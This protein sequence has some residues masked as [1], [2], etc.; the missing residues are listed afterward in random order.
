MSSNSSASGASGSVKKFEHGDEENY[1]GGVT[2]VAKPGDTDVVPVLTATDVAT[3][4][5]VATA[6][7]TAP[8]PP[9]FGKENSTLSVHSMMRNK[10][11]DD[12]YDL[13]ED[14]YAFMFV[15]PVISVPFLFSIY[16][17]SIKIVIYSILVGG[18]NYDDVMGGS[19]S[20]TAAKF[21]LIPVR[22]I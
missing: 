1:G 13:A 18:I 10:K 15:C 8:S 6:T 19:K 9:E 21:C 4:T 7:A 2:A 5:D 12:S 14:V 17:Y 11:E 20:A 22:Y 3:I 16:V